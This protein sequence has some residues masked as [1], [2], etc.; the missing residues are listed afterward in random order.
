MKEP[1]HVDAE[2]TIDEML[3]DEIVL[4]MMAA[5]RVD[6]SA[7]EAMLAEVAQTLSACARRRLPSEPRINPSLTR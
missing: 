3:C 5:D 7:L 1:L 2:L 4:A 6:R